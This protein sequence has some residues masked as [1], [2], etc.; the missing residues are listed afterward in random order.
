M[1]ELLILVDEADRELG[2][3]SVLESHS[4]EGILHR[5]FTILVFLSLIHI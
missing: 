3:A 1:S 4:G 5:A 2:T